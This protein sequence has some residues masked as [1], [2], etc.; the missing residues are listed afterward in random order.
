MRHRRRQDSNP[1][2][3]VV[4]TLLVAVVCV[5]GCLLSCVAP[6]LVEWR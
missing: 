6:R 4:Y 5:G 2:M 1:A 3:V